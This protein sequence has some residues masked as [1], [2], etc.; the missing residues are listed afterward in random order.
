MTL[1]FNAGR[2]EIE[3]LPLT[4]R[5]NLPLLWLSGLHLHG[6]GPQVVGDVFFRHPGERIQILQKSLDFRLHGE[7]VRLVLILLNFRNDFRH[8]PPFAEVD[9][10][11]VLQKIGIPLLQEQNV[12]LILAEE[13]NAGR[14]DRSQLFPIQFEMSLNEGS[15]LVQRFQQGVRQP[16]LRQRQTING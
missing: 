11:G 8:L 2:F 10:V 12:R 16:L 1:G 6:L 14:V 15:G 5:I 3:T 4:L 9:Q 13:G 7:T